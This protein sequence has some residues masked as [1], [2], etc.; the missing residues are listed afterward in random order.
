MF[1]KTLAAAALSLV[2]SVTAQAAPLSFKD[3]I[4][5]A[6]SCAGKKSDGPPFAIN[7]LSAIRLRAISIWIT[8]SENKWGANCRRRNRF[9]RP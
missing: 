5:E 7:L 4:L 8:G 3:K 1:R 2:F 9:R 6:K